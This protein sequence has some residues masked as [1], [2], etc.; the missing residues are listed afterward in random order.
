MIKD[1][2]T[3]V[4][5]QIDSKVADRLK[6]GE[7]IKGSI[8]WRVYDLFRRYGA[9][10]VYEDEEV[11]DVECYIVI[12]NTGIGD[13]YYTLLK[14]GGKTWGYLTRGLTR[15]FVEK[16]IDKYSRCIESSS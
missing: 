13:N 6:R 9:K 15:D 10:I 7:Y 16:I 5:E 12:L 11:D 14:I 4:S 3:I 1:I 2:F 8:A